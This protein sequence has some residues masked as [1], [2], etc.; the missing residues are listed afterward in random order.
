MGKRGPAPTPTEILKLRG[1]WRGTVNR[2]EPHP[3][4]GEP[5]C[6]F[7]DDR[8]E[9]RSIWKQV[10]EA[11]VPT[12]IITLADFA[13]IER[14][15]IY[16]VRWRMCEQHVK[17]FGVRCAVKAMNPK[18]FI[19]R[20]ANGMAIVDFIEWPEV[21]ESHQLDKDLKQ[22]E[23]SFGMTPSARSRLTAPSEPKAKEGKTKYLA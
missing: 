12:R 13:Q 2:N 17:K 16:L 23:A 3:E 18:R 10:C 14:Y 6:P 11:L 15:C 21:A 5:D 4:V 22:I 1:S 9:E 8:T 7:G 19:T 20:E